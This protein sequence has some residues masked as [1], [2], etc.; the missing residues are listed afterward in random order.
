MQFKAFVALTVIL[1]MTTIGLLVGLTGLLPEAQSAAMAGPAGTVT[2]G[3]LSSPGADVARYSIGFQEIEPVRHVQPPSPPIPGLLGGDLYV[4]ALD[5]VLGHE[6][7][8]QR[9]FVGTGPQSFRGERLWVAALTLAS[10]ETLQPIKG[11]CAMCRLNAVSR[12]AHCS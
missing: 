5:P 10:P 8:S 2:T 11:K 6:Y 12:I 3:P 4:S 9:F 1:R 7:T